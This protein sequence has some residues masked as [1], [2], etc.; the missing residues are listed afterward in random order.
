MAL[1]SHFS[2]HLCTSCTA[3]AECQNIPAQW[4]GEVGQ[5]CVAWRTWQNKAPLS[6]ALCFHWHE[7]PVKCSGKPSPGLCQKD[8]PGVWTHTTGSKDHQSHP[9]SRTVF[10]KP[11]R[12]LSPAAQDGLVTWSGARPTT[13]YPQRRQE[14]VGEPQGRQGWHSWT[15]I[16]GWGGVRWM[17]PG[18]LLPTA[19]DKWR[20][21]AEWIHQ[22]RKHNSQ[23][24]YGAL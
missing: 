3:P 9:T 14:G 16:Q 4:R 7:C 11:W 21:S 15:S 2:D 20:W 22:Q 17:W 5:S 6:R 24:S 13:G 23:G 1:W 8:F 18:H 19:F 10:S 12:E